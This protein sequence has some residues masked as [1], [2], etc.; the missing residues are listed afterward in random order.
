MIGQFSNQEDLTLTDLVRHNL[1]KRFQTVTFYVRV[2]AMY[3]TPVVLSPLLRAQSYESHC[4]F[5]VLY[6]LFLWLFQSMPP[7]IV[8]WLPL[9]LVPA[10]VNTKIEDLLIHYTSETMLLYI[11]YGMVLNGIEG[12]NL[13]KRLILTLLLIFGGKSGFIIGGF[14]TTTVLVSMWTNGVRTAAIVLPIAMEAIQHIQD[15]RL[16]HVFELRTRYVHKPVGIGTPI[17][18]ARYLIEGGI[19]IPDVIRILN[20]FFTVR[21]GLLIGISYSAVL[22][23]MGSVVGCGG[24]LFVKAFMEQIYDYHR[25]TIYNWFLCHMPLTV[26][27][28][29]LLWLVLSVCYSSD[30]LSSDHISKR[31]FEDVIYRRFAELGPITYTEFIPMVTIGL[32]GLAIVGVHYYS[33]L[34]HM[35]PMRTAFYENVFVFLAFMALYSAP[36][37]HATNIQQQSG[38]HPRHVT[39]LSLSIERLRLFC[40]GIAKVSWTPLFGHGLPGTFGT[41]MLD[42]K[43]RRLDAHKHTYIRRLMCRKCEMLSFAVLHALFGLTAAK[44]TFEQGTHRGGINPP[45]L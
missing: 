32:M 43:I 10:F 41:F 13:H 2:F 37:G 20:E 22:G 27:C 35:E 15:N 9:I 38:V 29:L 31:A 33:E 4:S 45:S 3:I 30:V 14:V 25:L 40:M 7:A 8:S 39:L 34:M 42:I 19:V 21:K 24:N 17:M 18:E 36:V 44:W 1:P 5:I 26:L 23:S 12:T 6:V 11:W 28:T 16:F